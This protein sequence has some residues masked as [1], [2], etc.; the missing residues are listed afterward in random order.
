[1]ANFI[2]FLC[3]IWPLRHW[4][5]GKFGQEQVANEIVDFVLNGIGAVR[6]E[7]TS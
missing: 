6:S 4:T 1:L 2:Y 3:C 7:G 5:I